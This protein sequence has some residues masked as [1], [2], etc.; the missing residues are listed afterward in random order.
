MKSVAESIGKFHFEKHIGYSAAG[1]T[2]LL[3]VGWKESTVP[4]IIKSRI[5]DSCYQKRLLLTSDIHR[6]MLSDYRITAFIH[7]KVICRDVFSRRYSLVFESEL[8]KLPVNELGYGNFSILCGKSSVN[9]ITETLKINVF[10]RRKAVQICIKSGCCRSVYH[11]VTDGN[12]LFCR[13]RT[14]EH[15]EE[16]YSYLFRQI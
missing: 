10:N 5:H 13:R 16:I 14:I 1:I 12:L 2:R 6:Q 8:L 4:I 11:H 15:R 9:R 3:C 7:G